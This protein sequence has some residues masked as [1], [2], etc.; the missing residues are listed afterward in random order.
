[1]ALFEGAT[2]R[3]LFNE[4]G[5]TRLEITGSGDYA[6]VQGNLITIDLAKIKSDKGYARLNAIK[7]NWG[8]TTTLNVLRLENFREASEANC[9]EHV[10]Y[11]KYTN[12]WEKIFS[13]DFAGLFKDKILECFGKSNI[14]EFGDLYLR[15][16]IADNT[17][18]SYIKGSDGLPISQK[19]PILTAAG[20]NRYYE[21]VGTLW[22]HQGANAFSSDADFSNAINVNVDMN[23]TTG[24][25]Q[26]NV[27]MVCLMT[28]DLT[29]ISP[30]L[31]PSNLKHKF[32][33][34]FIK[35]EDAL[36]V[37]FPL[38]ANSPTETFTK[39]V[40]G[41]NDSENTYYFQS[42]MAELYTR[43]TA[44]GKPLNGKTPKYAR[45]YLT[46]S[47]GVVMD[48]SSTFEAVG[49]NS[50]SYYQDKGS[51]GLVWT[52]DS[53]PGDFLIGNLS[54]TK[55]SS[56]SW[57]DLRVVCDLT[58]DLRS[59]YKVGDVLMEEPTQLAARLIIGFKDNAEPDGFEGVLSEDAFTHTKEVF[60]TAADISN[61]YVVLPL[62]ES[63]DKIL[64]EYNTTADALGNSLHLRW[65]V[66]YRN[67]VVANSE[68]LLAPNV[69]YAHKIKSGE[70]LY[71]NSATTG[72]PNP[73]N[74]YSTSSSDEVKNVLNVKFTKTDGSKQ[75]TDYKIIVV[76]SNDIS[77]FNGQE[78]NGSGDLEKEPRRLNMKYTFS[79][80][81]ESDF[82]FVHYKGASGRDYITHTDDASI[83]TTKPTSQSS[84]NET[85]DN[86]ENAAIDIRQ[87]VHTVEYDVFINKNGGAKS[88][89]LPFEGYTGTEGNNLEPMAYI[90]WYDWATDLNSTRLNQV[91]TW[92]ENK[93][94]NSV[95][96]GFFML[97]N[98]W[99]G[100][101]PTHSKVGVTYDPSSLT[102][103]GDIIACDV[104]KYYDGIFKGVSADPRGDFA[105]QGYTVPVLVHE[106]TLSTRYLFHIYPS[107]VVADKITTASNRYLSTVNE[108]KAGTKTFSQVR[109]S[110][111]DFYENNGRVIVS[112]NGTTGDFALR[113]QLQSIDNYFVVENEPCTDIRWVAYFEDEKGLWEPTELWALTVKEQRGRVFKFD[114]SSLTG[115]YTLL[116]NSSETKTVTASTGMRFH[117]IGVARDGSWHQA[118]VIH[119]ELQFINAPAYLAEELTTKDVKR[120]DEYMSLHLDHAGVVN[121]D[122]YFPDTNE[123]TTEEE[124]IRTM[125]LDWKEAEYGFCYPSIDRFRIATGYS[126]LT[127]IHGDYILLKTM[128]K[129][130]ISAGTSWGNM[131]NNNPDAGYN[132]TYLW[133]NWDGI[134]LDD[135]TH[136]VTDN[137]RYGAFFYV[138]ASD[139]SRTIATLDF[140]AHLCQGSQ[141]YFTAAIADV[142]S[143]GL[144]SP[145]LM[146]HVYAFDPTT[147]EK[148]QVISFLTCVLNTVSNNDDGYQY[149]KW[150]Q[151]YGYGTIPE[152]I[153][154][155]N[156]EDFTV[157]I[158]NYSKDTNGADFCVDQI[159]FYTSTAQVNILQD[160]VAC[161]TDNITMRI[162]MDGETLKTALGASDTSKD[163]Y[164]SICDE[165]GTPVE[166]NVI[167]EGTVSGTDKFGKRSVIPN[168]TLN[169]D[170]TLTAASIA[171]GFYK[172][173]D[174]NVYFTLLEKPLPLEEGKRYYV[175][176]YSLGNIPTVDS[177]SPAS[178]WGSPE[179]GC[180]VCSG[181]FVAQKMHLTFSS[182]GGDV[183]GTVVGNCDGSPVDVSTGMELKRPDSTNP[184]GF[185]TYSNLPFDFYRG[186]KEELLASTSVASLDY[187]TEAIRA[188]R[189]W[190]YSQHSS[191]YTD[192][193]TN[194]SG[195]AADIA[196]FKASDDT[197]GAI[198][199]TMATTGDLILSATQTFKDQMYGTDKK[200]FNYLAFS[201]SENTLDSKVICSPLAFSF[202]YDPTYSTP[203]ITLGFSDVTYPDDNRGVRLGLE[204]LN[205]MKNDY[206]VHI[207]VHSYL[208]KDRD[209]I[210][211]SQ[212]ALTIKGNLVLYSSTDPVVQADL[213]VNGIRTAAVFT[214]SSVNADNMYISLNFHGT[215]VDDIQYHEGYS[216]DMMFEYRESD[217]AD[218]LCDPTCLLTLKVV[219]KYVTWNQTEIT[220]NDNWSNDGSWKRSVKEELY[221]TNYQNNTDINTSLDNSHANYVPMKFTYV[222]IPT[223]NKAPNLKYL[224][225]GSN[226]LYNNVGSNATI[227]I[228]YDMM[229]RY[230]EDG[231]HGHS[232][233]SGT[234]TATGTSIYDCEKFYSN[235]CK[236]IYFKPGAELLNQQYL[237]YEK[238]WVEKEM[239]A[240]RWYLMSA[241]LQNTYAG[242]MYVPYSSV[243]ANK[244]RQITE[245][246]QSITFNS[247]NYSRT[248]YPIYQRLWKQTGAKVY[249]KTYDIRQTDYSA[250]LNFGA[251]S[252]V[253]TEWSHTYNDVQVPYT[254]LTGFSIR[255]H[256]KDQ[257]ANALIRLPKEDTSYDYYQWDN[258]SPTDGKL[259][260][261]V[262]KPV[263]GKLLTDGMANISGVTYGVAYGTQARTAGDGTQTE[264]LSNLQS[265]D[266]YVLVGNPYM[267]SIKMSEFFT[268]NNSVLNDHNYWTYEAN[269][270]GAYKDAGTIKP[271]QAFFVKAT[272]NILFTPAMMIDGN[273]APESATAQ[274]RPRVTMTAAN[275]RG[276]SSASV[277]M[278]DE[279]SADYISSEDVETLFDSN[280]SDVPMIYTVAGDRAVSIDVRPDFGMVPFGVACASSDQPVEVTIDTSL[281][282]FDA[283]TGE[284]NAVSEGSS[285]TI[286]PND[287]GRY[288]LT[289][290]KDIT[291]IREMQT[292]EG[293][294]VSV[295]G[296]TVTV[297][298]TSRLKSVRVLTI[299]GDIVASQKNCG[300]ETTLDLA[301]GGV[302]LVETQT[303]T[304]QKVIKVMAR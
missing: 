64:S 165:T 16:Y 69:W 147:G 65:Y 57:K 206:T 26:S 61:G 78:V 93:T 266:G 82:Q 243:E 136:T 75:W 133:Y 178:G 117:V 200:E 158:D 94:E 58:D 161:G 124:N 187:I 66:T 271:L 46:S 90:R 89:L 262:T 174:G 103:A 298:S 155:S 220:G 202:S 164:W 169:A 197:N 7:V 135:Y 196:S 14:N 131:S 233:S 36:S 109:T 34:R 291:G 251:V 152:Y 20:S 153:D 2:P 198:I 28:D 186:T 204:Q 288:F 237:T 248:L 302:F 260:Q 87:G 304:C 119:Y 172:G 10:L 114:L 255:A 80:Y 45:F 227:N 130:G 110:I 154:I 22:F 297:R 303:A 129:A 142:T 62:S 53:W 242:D 213:T 118:G 81:N 121:F 193:Q 244:G 234:Y 31:E 286:Q 41:M 139:E 181:Y 166:S 272:G 277:E 19:E 54:V 100:Q 55:S 51:K 301:V 218:G 245:A 137:N 258:T 285:F 283:V 257:A 230:G 70:G 267:S 276:S 44:A 115:S 205:N 168:Y 120:T 295:R 228:E 278:D 56:Q 184:S 253:A 38:S 98:S 185:V 91:G 143:S 37:G 8:A 268:V 290:N 96:R 221:S 17:T 215:G 225:T 209:N 144:T 261:N 241:P 179:I 252:S 160:D 199:E 99:G 40:E 274:A 299:G 113:A 247:T 176:I 1:M 123:P 74:S 15:W 216:Y 126:G 18:N 106:P 300:T 21:N 275:S 79:I 231:C 289:T 156:Y 265:N 5:S 141:I 238:A 102:D 162:Y 157:D 68:S 211:P 219:P 280:L 72:Y 111:F 32:I 59:S 163:I 140:N 192:Y 39:R 173:S 273:T 263:T 201:I 296:K 29:G 134:E 246:F 145:Q 239:V 13:I 151:V 42:A 189:S 207:P 170:G 259:T 249:T 97:N 203:L 146:A 294:V 83:S 284:T 188:F 25:F 43:A 214:Q 30:Q 63:F 86:I 177:P 264:T 108:L 104:S 92:L 175:S 254:T 85:T 226:G 35:E 105:A 183:T 250:N 229:V 95:S 50:L 208:D 88:I 223:A 128:K 52:S 12:E 127:P 48:A 77:E 24:F 148:I 49:G 76:M 269:T 138:D 6:S 217:D 159:T 84:W 270:V 194:P 232:T 116:S 292:D 27:H 236:E 235:W 67:E 73:W 101:K 279:A 132:H 191:S 210:K 190:D 149:N 167:Y 182:F 122:N 150:Y 256:K 293:V 222:T 125:P 23:S 195:L 281:Y 60:M 3:F 171:Q 212:R 71:W 4:D 107:S 11:V 112:L 180:T 287:Y 9:V 224:T 240:N 47:S 282:V 33:I